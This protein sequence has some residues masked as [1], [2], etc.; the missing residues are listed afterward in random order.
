MAVVLPT[1]EVI[2]ELKNLNQA[3]L[4]IAK[5]KIVHHIYVT[6]FQIVKNILIPCHGKRKLLLLFFSLQFRQVTIFF[7]SLTFLATQL[8]SFF[9]FFSPLPYGN[10][11][12]LILFFSLS[13]LLQFWQLHYHNFYFFSLSFSS[14]SLI[15]VAWILGRNFGNYIIEI[16]LSLSLSITSFLS[17]LMLFLRISVIPLPKF[18]SL[19]IFPNKF[20]Q[21][22][23]HK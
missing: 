21:C 20:E 13:S 18:A 15:W 3:V 12:A 2:E 23:Y 9:F 11:I 7:F 22:P 4:Y 14:T 19:L 6:S 17:L 8:S 5:E 16:Q 1:W 10:S